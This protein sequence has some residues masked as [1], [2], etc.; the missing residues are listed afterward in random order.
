[1]HLSYEVVKYCLMNQ[2]INNR[3]K[4]LKQFTFTNCSIANHKDNRNTIVP[5]C[6]FRIIVTLSYINTF[7][8]KHIDTSTKNIKLTLTIRNILDKLFHFQVKLKFTA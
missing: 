4:P 2:C 6:C 3:K 7:K 8:Q 5:V 1:M